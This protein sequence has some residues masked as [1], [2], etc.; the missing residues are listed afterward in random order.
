MNE[1]SHL[2]ATRLSVRASGLRL[3][4]QN[5]E[6][7]ARASEATDA[8]QDLEL[9]DVNF[10][11]DNP[12][13]EEAGAINDRPHLTLDR[14][15]LTAFNHFI[16]IQK[17]PGRF[18]DYDG[19]SY[20]RGSAHQGQ[21]QAAHE[22]AGRWQVLLARL[23]GF[24]VDQ[25]IHA[26]LAD[27]YVH[28][29]G[30]KWYRN[31]SPSLERYSYPQDQGRYAG[32]RAELAARFPLAEGRGRKGRGVP[33]SVFMPVDN[34]ARYWWG[35]FRQQ[36]E[37]IEHLG[38]VLHA[39]QDASVPH[40]AAGYNGNWHVQYENRLD[41]L[42]RGWAKD[43]RVLAETRRL[44]RTWQGRPSAA[45]RRRLDPADRERRPAL[46]WP[47]QQSVTWLALHAFHEYRETY[48]CFRAG[49]AEN[50][51]SMRKLFVLAV[52]LGALVLKAALR[53]RR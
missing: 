33:Y 4:R 1:L 44:L 5:G 43:P 6:R 2:L 3:G 36:S 21:Y 14:R 50:R 37:R 12:H 52:A 47:I 29:P 46:N 23:S 24:K 25:A 7:L 10:G 9:V 35:R 30:R 11:R 40:H 48:Q 38:P 39:V 17:G 45:T 26:W 51:G 20:C 34:L 18:D 16:D 32:K 15:T 13:R 27:M 31:C 53:L 41:E 49:W 42:A 8:F 19:Y 22:V 28:A